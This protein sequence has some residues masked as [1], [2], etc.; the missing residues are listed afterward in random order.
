MPPK[1]GKVIKLHDEMQRLANFKPETYD[2]DKRTIDVTFSTGAR[3]RRTTYY[4]DR[5]IEEL[6]M[7]PSSVNL[8]RF[9]NGAPVLNSHNRYSL[10]S[11]MGV[12]EHA[13]IEAGLGIATI[14]FSEREDIQP[15]ITDILSGVIRNVSVGY[16]INR[17]KEEDDLDGIPLYRVIDWT[18]T[19]LSF[20]TVP[21]DH[22]AQVRSGSYHPIYECEV[23]RRE[24]EEKEPIIEDIETAPS[25]RTQIDDKNNTVQEQVMPPLDENELIKVRKEGADLE[26]KRVSEIKYAV[27]KSGLSEDFETRM[28][29]EGLSIEKVRELLIEELASR[30]SQNNTNATN[31][32]VG[33]DNTRMFAKTGIEEAILNRF[34]PSKTKITDNSKRFANMRMAK[35]AECSLRAA[36]VNVDNMTEHQIVKQA[37]RSPGYHSSSDFPLILE[38]V[39]TKTLQRG[40]ME[41]PRTW[42]PMTASVTVSDFKQVSR[43]HLGEASQ[44]EE[45]LEGGEY[46]HGKIGERA[47]KY[48]ISKFG[49]MIAVTWEMLV[50]DDMSAFTRIPMKLGKKARDLESDKVWG[51]ITANAQVMAE[52]G[53]TLFHANHSNLNEGGAGA[54]SET[55]LA[56]M[57][58]AMRLHQDLDG[59]SP[60]NLFPS[61]I[62]VPAAREVEATKI[63][64]A[65]TP[66]QAA[67]VNVFGQNSGFFLRAAVE[68]RLDFVANN[69]WLVT[70]DTNQCEMIEV[71]R[72]AGEES[73][74]VE[75]RNGFE[76]DGQ[77]FKIR[78]L[79]VAHALDYRGF[80]FN[81]GA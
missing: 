37:L 28:I 40:Y 16:Q 64:S 35:L 53:N 36:G 2:K 33:E 62:F 44:L 75:S 70:S 71:A 80:Q 41:A 19:E 74:M 57:R 66:N 39:I 8:E 29:D 27:K 81:A 25:E 54:V 26:R 58:E 79:F 9:L 49:K 7:S 12:I 24:P 63:L 14:R 6:D 23:I 3:V 1:S 43:T 47:E 34:D 11:I 55:T 65:I 50:N 30:D 18:P 52:T 22:K 67:D 20:V 51:L 46:K 72:L 68:P 56:A 76:V 17:V 60:L 59:S 10:D 15:L 69:P 61:Y 13:K 38:N 42:E 5:F 48:S 21:A 77:E 45:V 4:G 31:I 73:P 32:E 78:H